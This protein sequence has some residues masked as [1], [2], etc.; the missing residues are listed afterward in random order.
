M[1]PFISE[2]YWSIEADLALAGG[3]RFS[4]RLTHLDGNKLGKLDI[5]TEDVATTAA[6][7]IRA[8]TL[9][10]QSVETRR[11]KRNPQPPFTTS[12]LQQEASRKLGFQHPVPCKSPKSC[13]R[14]SALAAKPPA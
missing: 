6:D 7:R 4:A 2:E 9:D 12:T 11:I 13:M 3:D 1:K 5:K 14:G 10:V 8:T